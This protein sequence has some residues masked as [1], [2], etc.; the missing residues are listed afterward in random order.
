MRDDAVRLTVHAAEP[1]RAS[2]GEQVSDLE[3]GLG[4]ACVSD[5]EVSSDLV[6]APEATQYI[7]VFLI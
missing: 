1:V 6:A 3:D 2:T 4:L 5:L 7:V